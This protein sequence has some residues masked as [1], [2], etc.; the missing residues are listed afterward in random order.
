[1]PNWRHE[2]AVIGIRNWLNGIDV[3]H[4][5]DGRLR[6]PRGNEPAWLQAAKNLGCI[7]SN[8]LTGLRENVVRITVAG[9][10]QRCVAMGC[11]RF[12]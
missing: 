9:V 8:G 1:M 3:C 12:G 5:T 6:L 7:P 10:G 4:E 11:S 2:E